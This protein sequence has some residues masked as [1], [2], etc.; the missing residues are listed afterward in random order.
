MSNRNAVKIIESEIEY[1]KKLVKETGTIFP[2]NNDDLM[3]ATRSNLIGKYN[4]TILTLERIK[5]R[6]SA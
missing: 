2:D 6:I 3:M 5:D 4:Y 1:F